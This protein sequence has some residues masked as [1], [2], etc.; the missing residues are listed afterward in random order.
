MPDFFGWVEKNVTLNFKEPRYKQA[1]IDIDLP[2]NLNHEFM[3]ELIDQK[4]FSRCSFL[5]WD[6]IMHSHGATVR[7][8]YALRYSKLDRHVDVVVYPN[9]TE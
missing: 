1:D 8:V 6:R 5:K 7:E 9:S 3:S 2:K 4:M